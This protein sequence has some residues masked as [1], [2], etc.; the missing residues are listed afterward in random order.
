MTRATTI[1]TPREIWLGK[2]ALSGV[3]ARLGRDKEAEAELVSA[4]RTIETILGGL[5]TPRLR[6]SFIGAAP[7]RAIYHTLGRRPPTST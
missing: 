5:S 2:A 7:V 4:V 3:L 6:E 1:N